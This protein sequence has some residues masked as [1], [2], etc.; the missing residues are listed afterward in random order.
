MAKKYDLNTHSIENADKRLKK[1]ICFVEATSNEYHKIWEEYRFEQDNPGLLI[2]VGNVG[3]NHVSV[4][5]SFV[6]LDGEYIC[7]YEPTSQVV[8]HE[9]IEKWI[10]SFAPKGEKRIDFMCDAANFHNAVWLVEKKTGRK[11]K[12]IDMFRLVEWAKGLTRN[13]DNELL[14][15][16]LP[17]ETVEMLQKC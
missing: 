8:H 15:K 3:K 10:M 14:L 5:F 1:T 4:S 13:K 7:M 11:V 9:L 12:R 2:N 6:K 17:Q 16:G